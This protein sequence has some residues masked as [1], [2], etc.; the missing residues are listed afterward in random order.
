MA[1]PL[2]IEYPGAVLHVTSLGN[3]RNNI[4]VNVQDRRDY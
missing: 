4:Y 1:S 2:R 3:A